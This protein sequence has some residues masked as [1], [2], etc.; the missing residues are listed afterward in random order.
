MSKAKGV[1][2]RKEKVWEK[3]QPLLWGGEI[4]KALRAQ[5]RVGLIKQSF[6]ESA[7]LKIS[8]MKIR[9]SEI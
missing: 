1:D 5:T 9:K 8:R 4:I 3:N 2:K 6:G 7:R